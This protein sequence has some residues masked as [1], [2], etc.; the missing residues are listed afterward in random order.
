MISLIVFI[1]AL[2]IFIGLFSQ[3]IQSAMAYQSHSS[4]STKTSDLLDT[5]LL[6][7]GVNATWGTDGTIPS[8]FGLQDPEFTQYQSAL[9]LLC[10][11]APSTGNVVEYDKSSPSIYYSNLT[12]AFS[13]LLLTPKGQDIN[14]STALSLLGINNTYSF[15]LISPQTLQF[16]YPKR[17]PAPR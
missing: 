17:K 3:N 12:S 11:W 6:N 13:V 15:Q 8:G 5:M 9:F 14:Y 16:L 7:P 4:L 1:A 10:G 2:M